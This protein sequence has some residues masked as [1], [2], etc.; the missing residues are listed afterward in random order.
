MLSVALS[1]YHKG[2]GRYVHP[3]L[4][5]YRAHSDRHQNDQTRL[6]SGPSKITGIDLD[7]GIPLLSRSCPAGHGPL[8]LGS[9]TALR[10]SSYSP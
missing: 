8:A 4:N 6:K 9:P 7:S 2:K 1:P 10:S 5:E 3:A